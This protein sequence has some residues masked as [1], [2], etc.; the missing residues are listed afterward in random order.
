MSDENTIIEINGVKMEVD[1]RQA[2]RIQEIRVGARVKALRKKYGDSYEV[3]PGI[4]IGFEPFKNLPTIIV[5]LAKV[6]Y[7]S[8]SL[9]FLYYNAK[10][11]NVELVVA[12]DDDAAALDKAD[13]VKQIDKEIAKKQLEIQD[14]ENHKAYFLAKFKSYWEPA[15][16]AMAD[17][18]S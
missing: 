18:L 6:D 7:S 14:L 9:E 12:A 15:E 3:V 4:V 5:A 1:L 11:E 17:A 2:R 10:S 13:F 16:Q 8:A